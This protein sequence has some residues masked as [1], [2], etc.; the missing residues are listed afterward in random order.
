MEYHIILVKFLNC[1]DFVDEYM[2]GHIASLKSHVGSEA[3]SRRMQIIVGKKQLWEVAKKTVLQTKL[4]SLA[5]VY[6]HV[7]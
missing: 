1:V 2:A 4:T 7:Q 3:R 6:L 5:V